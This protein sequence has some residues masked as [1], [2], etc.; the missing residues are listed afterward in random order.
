[1]TSSQVDEGIELY[2]RPRL[3]ALIAWTMACDQPGH[4]LLHVVPGPEASRQALLQ[5][6]DRGEWRRFQPGVASAVMGPES[7][8]RDDIVG[9]LANKLSKMPVANDERLAPWFI[10]NG[11]WQLLW[12]LIAVEDLAIEEPLRSAVDHGS[13]FIHEVYRALWEARFLVAEHST[14]EPAT[15]FVATMVRWLTG[16]E[17][18]PEDHNCLAVSGLHRRIMRDQERIGALLFLVT[19]ATQ[20][21]LISKLVVGFDCLEAAC[22]VNERGV[23]RQLHVLIGVA[24]RWVHMFKSPIGFVIGFNETKL[25]AL[26]KLNPRLASFVHES[27]ERNA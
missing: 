23:L 21:G 19:L 20:N 4:P 12:G 11:A 17:L 16:S 9:A 14:L 24:D 27:L 10:P 15:A 5:A 26:R 22:C 3:D 7:W 13:L 6:F 8:L 18:H 2:R 1:M 25:Q